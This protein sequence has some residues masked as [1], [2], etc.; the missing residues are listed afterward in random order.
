[1]RKHTDPGR[2]NRCKLLA[3]HYGDDAR[4][5]SCHTGVDCNDLRMSMRRAQE[6]N[7][8]HP[9]QFDVA[10]IKPASLH[11]PLEVWAWHHLSDIRVWPIE[12]RDTFWSYRTGAHCLR[13]IRSRA[14]V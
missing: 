9:W 7:M 1:M 5:P 12:Q 14:V 8:G 11:Q 3:C 10:H 6:Y 4:H 13:P 2:N